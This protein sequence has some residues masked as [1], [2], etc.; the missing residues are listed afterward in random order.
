M[1]P[2]EQAV[3]LRAVAEQLVPRNPGIEIG[4]TDDAVVCKSA[5]DKSWVML[6]SATIDG[7]IAYCACSDQAFP[8]YAALGE[9]R[10]PI[11]PI[12]PFAFENWRTR[13]DQSAD[14]KSLAKQHAKE[15]HQR[16][17]L[18]SDQYETRIR[19]IDVAEPAAHP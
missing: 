2:A 18:T 4:L 19:E 14:E 11:E 7:R 13:R 16:G 9:Q 17:Y 8:R 1:T 15:C 12:G 10:K 5:D 3:R 6:Y